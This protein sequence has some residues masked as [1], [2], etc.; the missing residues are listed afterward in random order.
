MKRHAETELETRVGNCCGD[1]CSDRY[2]VS[3][4]KIPGIYK[5]RC[6]ACFEKETGYRHH[7][8]PSV[9]NRPPHLYVLNQ[10]NDNA[11]CLGCGEPP[12]S[13]IHNVA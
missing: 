2:P 13:A 3:L 5:Y 9:V 10:K 12:E 4:Y 8:S 11:K 1:N 6:A 7:L